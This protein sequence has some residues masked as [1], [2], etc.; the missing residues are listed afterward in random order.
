MINLQLKDIVG[1]RPV[2]QELIKVKMPVKTSYRLTRLI[3]KFNDELS[4]LSSSVESIKLELAA[5]N[6][7]AK[8]QEE[9][10]NKRV[11]E[12]LEVEL[13]FEDFTP[14]TLDELGDSMITPEQLLVC[15]KIFA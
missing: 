11:N 5:E 6:L 12:L 15:E 3:K 4:T 2:L 13:K 7:F 1:M 8:D 9:E 10:L 14:I